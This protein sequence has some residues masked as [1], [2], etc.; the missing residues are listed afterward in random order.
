MDFKDISSL[1]DH[2][3]EATTLAIYLESTAEDELTSKVLDALEGV[4][5]NGV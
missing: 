5:I 2:A 4:D 3:D 1:L